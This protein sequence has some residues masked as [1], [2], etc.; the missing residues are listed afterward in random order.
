M[1]QWNSET[2]CL[3]CIF[4][5]SF[6]KKILGSCFISP[7]P[8]C[9]HLRA[10]QIA[11]SFVRIFYFYFFFAKSKEWKL[12]HRKIVICSPGMEIANKMTN[13]GVSNCQIIVQT[14]NQREKE[15]KT[16]LIQKL[17]DVELNN[18]HVVIIFQLNL[19]MLTKAKITNLKT[20]INNSMTNIK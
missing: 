4:L 10:E 14:I 11:F 9:V 2:F 6:W 20:I 1:K 12:F 16:L 13:A 3:N 15:I 5:P 8:P 7:S 17:C 18:I 19:K